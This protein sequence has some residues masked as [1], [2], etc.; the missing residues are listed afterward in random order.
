VINFFVF[1]ASL[2]RV[3]KY[4][5]LVV[6]LLL[7]C[8]NLESGFAA[9]DNSKCK[10]PGNFEKVGSEFYQ[11]IK[12]GSSLRLKKVNITSWQT[13]LLKSIALKKVPSN[14]VDP[15]ENAAGWSSN[16]FMGKMIWKSDE[17]VDLMSDGVPIQ[18][19]NGT[20]VLLM[21]DSLAPAIGPAFLQLQKTYNWNFRVIF[22]SSCQISDTKIIYKDKADLE[23][24][25]LA[26]LERLK[27]I[28]EFKPSILVLIEDPLNPVLPNKG[29]TPFQTWRA[30][31]A[32]SL[33]VFAKQ[34]PMKTVLLSRPVG[35]NKA[36]QNCLKGRSEITTQC[37]GKV[38]T[39]LNL[40]LAQ[41]M[42]TEKAGGLFVDLTTS[43]C[44]NGTC[45]PFI[46]NAL[47]YR[48]HIHFTYAFAEKLGIELE[49]F[50]KFD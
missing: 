13:E 30:S 50:F 47:V 16:P 19:G 22:R 41:K 26:R 20:K 15:I 43:L 28:T 11:C 9:S 45:P 8:I 42:E 3:R 17:G 39:D 10:V 33:S 23:K 2:G 48:D 40:R 14:L 31:F 44:M 35:V 32:R 18:N 38:S 46:A 7:L 21:G 12:S 25:A 6:T 1:S 36:L 29:E 24:C 49:E 34:V 4:C 5:I 37:F 27:V